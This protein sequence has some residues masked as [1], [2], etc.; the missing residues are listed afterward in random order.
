M[1]KGFVV[2]TDYILWATHV[3]TGEKI[4]PYRIL[5]GKHRERDH[6]QNLAVDGIKGNF[7]LLS[8]P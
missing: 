8:T 2:Y 6:L 5:V 7:Y 1:M 3:Y 4:H